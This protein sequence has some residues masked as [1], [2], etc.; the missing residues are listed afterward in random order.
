MLEAERLRGVGQHRS[1]LS[2]GMACIAPSA[3]E[4]QLQLSHR[5]PESRAK[6]VG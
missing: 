3:G 1:A 4:H 6:I 5:V 2:E